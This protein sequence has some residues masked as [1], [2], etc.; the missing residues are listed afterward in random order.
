MGWLDS[1]Q[2][3]ARHGRKQARPQ[4]SLGGMSRDEIFN[5]YGN[6]GDRFKKGA[7]DQQEIA[8][9]NRARFD[10]T[11]NRFLDLFGGGQQAL[12]E[13]TRGAVSAGMP[14]F[15]QALQGV[16]A[17]AQR[18]GIG[19]GDLGTTYEGNLASAFQQNIA[20]AVAQ[21]ALGLYGQRLGAAGNLLGLES[22]R[23]IESRNTYLDI[24]GNMV[25]G[26][27]AKKANKQAM[28]G[29]ALGGLFNLGGMALGGYLGGGFGGK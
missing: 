9:E 19:T 12:E 28:I 14:Q 11:R 15:M 17:N 2:D 21:Q 27:R 23:E 8:G 22:G 29:G 13:S 4:E 7:L 24:I 18:R 1:Y 6:S 10:E 16:R 3:V 25:E 20:D 26:D 5:T